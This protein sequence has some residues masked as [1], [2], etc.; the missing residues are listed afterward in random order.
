MRTTLTNLE[1]TNIMN[2]VNS[3]NSVAKNTTM[4]F[5]IKFAWKFKKNIKRLADAYDTFIKMRE[6][7]MKEYSGDEFSY[8]EE[9]T[10]N[11]YVKQEYMNEYYGKI[12]EL[13]LQTTEIEIDKVKLEELAADMD[14]FELSI[15]ELEALSF[16]IDD[17]DEAERVEGEV[18]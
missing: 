6:E 7:I 5:T 11:R 8:E 13:F 10:G 17:T 12:N 3:E 18:E 1:I 14:K 2:Y 16:M 9:G 4:K 15:P